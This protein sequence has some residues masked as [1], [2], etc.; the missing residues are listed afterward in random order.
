VGSFQGEKIAILLHLWIFI[1][2]TNLSGGGQ[3]FS[4]FGDLMVHTMELNWGKP[5][6]HKPLPSPMSKNAFCQMLCLYNCVW[7]PWQNMWIY[8]ISGKKRGF[9]PHETK[10][11]RVGSGYYELAL[12]QCI[13]YQE[14]LVKKNIA[15]NILR[16]RHGSRPKYHMHTVPITHDCLRCDGWDASERRQSG[17]VRRTLNEAHLD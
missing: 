4:F 9:W 15:E 14:L 3:C 6:Y 5:L 17:S 11:P 10:R 2:D 16:A 7:P 12:A 13:S 1:Y 8:S